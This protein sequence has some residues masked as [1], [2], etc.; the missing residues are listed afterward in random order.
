MIFKILVWGLV[1]AQCV[2]VCAQRSDVYGVCYVCNDCA[3][4]VHMSGVWCYVRVV[5]VQMSCVCGVM[6]AWCVCVN[7][8]YVWC[9]VCVVCV[10]ANVQCACMMCA[11]CV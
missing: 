6:C 5:C 1:C 8:W 2:C 3:W 9:Y 10:H 7:F 11:W 4:C